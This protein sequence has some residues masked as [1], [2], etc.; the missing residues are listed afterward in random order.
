MQRAAAC[1]GNPDEGDQ[2]LAIRHPASNESPPRHTGRG[3]SLYAAASTLGG[4]DGGAPNS[5][6]RFEGAGLTPSAKPNRDA[7][8]QRLMREAGLEPKRFH[9]LRRITATLMLGVGV[10]PETIL[11]TLGHAS[12][13]T[14]VGHLRARADVDATRRC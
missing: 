10:S 7:P 5:G 6:F 3:A 9:D 11:E 13:R 8:V 2:P 1:G 14:D 4:S 12:F